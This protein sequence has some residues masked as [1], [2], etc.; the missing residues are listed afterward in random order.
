MTGREVTKDTCAATEAYCR[1][2]LTCHVRLTPC[3][4]AVSTNFQDGRHSCGRRYLASGSSELAKFGNTMINRNWK[5]CTSVVRE[6]SPIRHPY[7]F[8]GC[9]ATPKRAGRFRFTRDR[10]NSAAKLLQ[11]IFFF[12]IK[13]YFSSGVRKWTS[14]AMRF[15]PAGRRPCLLFPFKN[16]TKAAAP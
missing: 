1:K 9:C 7:L 14:R 15:S 11:Y 13:V 3:S 16:P 8:R 10:S 4:E 2:I 12:S 5:G 6:I